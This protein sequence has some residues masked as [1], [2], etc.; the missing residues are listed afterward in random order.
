MKVMGGE[1]IAIEWLESESDTVLK[2]TALCSCHLSMS[3]SIQNVVLLVIAYFS[4]TEIV[5]MESASDSTL[6]LRWFGTIALFVYNIKEIRIYC[7]SDTTSIE[8]PHLVWNQWFTLTNRQLITKNLNGKR[9]S[10]SFKSNGKNLD[11]WPS[12][13]SPPSDAS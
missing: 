7:S 13:L 3:L 8:L 12:Q 4:S 10:I 5:T 11:P 2:R 6:T 9:M 1:R